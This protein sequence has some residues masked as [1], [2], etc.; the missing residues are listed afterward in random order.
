LERE[1][2]KSGSTGGGSK[3]N[4]EEEAK[5]GEKSVGTTDGFSLYRDRLVRK[6]G[7]VKGQ[8][9]LGGPWAI[10]RLRSQMVNGCKGGMSKKVELC[11]GGLLEVLDRGET[12]ISLG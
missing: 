10:K 5:F 1:R 11:R 12:R 9:S 7:S 4:G 2:K 3:S 8:G 6:Q